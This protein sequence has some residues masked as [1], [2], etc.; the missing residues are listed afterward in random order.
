MALVAGA[1]GIVGNNTVLFMSAAVGLTFAAYGYATS[2]VEA[3]FAVSR[4]VSDESPT[5]GQ[6]VAVSVTVRNESDELVPD[7]RVVDRVPEKLGVVEGSPRHAATLQP[8]ESTTFSYVV[9][10]RRGQHEFQE[11]TLLARNVSADEESLSTVHAQTHVTVTADVGDVPLSSQTIQQSGMVSTSVGGEGVEFYQSR[12][13]HSSD[14][15]NRVDWKRYAKT[16]ELTTVEFREERAANVVVLVDVRS[17]SR[18][19]RRADEPDAMSLS[20]FAAGRV[21]AQ[22]LDEGNQVGLAFYGHDSEYLSPGT[23]D[24]HAV[25][26]EEMLTSSSDSSVPVVTD[27]GFRTYNSDWRVDWLRKRLPEGA[28]VVFV[29]PLPDVE[30]AQTAQRLEASGH[31][32]RIL[33]PD[34]TTTATPGSTVERIEWLHRVRE[35]R[36]SGVKVA[37]WSPDEPLRSA[38]RRARR[39]WSP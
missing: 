1:L 12:D 13:Y 39:R 21:V 24:G 9:R 14:P 17:E 22:L 35:V 10:A 28:Q 5:A 8:G 20:K 31:D 25:E 37:E 15:M 16:R 2:P 19:A 26:I 3:T 33:A 7:L 36:E 6:D 38:F 4:E 30:P 11:T 18:V 29:T 23:G 34:V 27:G 32:V